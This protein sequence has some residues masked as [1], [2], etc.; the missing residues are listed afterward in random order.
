DTVEPALGSGLL[1]FR[2]LAAMTIVDPPAV[3]GGLD[4]AQVDGLLDLDAEA[5]RAVA[6]EVVDLMADYLARIETFAV[7]PPVE[8]GTIAPLF[9]RQAPE[10]PEPIEAILDDY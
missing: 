4:P 6:H 3:P 5:F 9:P 1:H 10:K 2:R 8:P 7:L